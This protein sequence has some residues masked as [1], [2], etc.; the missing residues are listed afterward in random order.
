MA[1][2]GKHSSHLENISDHAVIIARR[3]R[4]LI[5]ERNLEEDDGMARVFEQ[6]RG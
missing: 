3:V 5:Q 6:A 2:N 1:L 4:A